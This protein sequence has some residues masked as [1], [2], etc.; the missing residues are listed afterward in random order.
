MQAY[1]KNFLNEFNYEDDAKQSLINDF[2][3]IYANEKALNIYKEVISIY[4]KDRFCDYANLIKMSKDASEI[5]S[6]HEYS[7]ALLI[8]IFMAKRLKEYYKELGL[9]EEMYNTTVCDLKYK[10][11]ECYLVKGI[12]GSFVGIWFA[13]FFKV[14]RFG[15]DNLQFEI[16]DC[17]FEYNYKGIQIAKD[18]KVMN[19]HLPRTG[20]RLDKDAMMITLKKAQDFLVERFN[21][22][23]PIF[24]CHSWLL[25]KN[26]VGAYKEGS[27]LKAFA[28]LFDIVYSGDYDSYEQV[29]RLF[30]MDYTDDYSKFPQDSSF[31]RYVVKLMQ[32]KKAFGYGVGIFTLE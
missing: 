15:I 31:R 17:G 21:L 19:I 24:Y 26:I 28:D 2:D 9:T 3:K 23:T 1:L 29:W 13:G 10:A 32:D 6:I 25:H 16:I 11:I 14:E 27:N 5:A 4:D 22:E 18:T 12:W 7:S 30:D 20:G 8:F